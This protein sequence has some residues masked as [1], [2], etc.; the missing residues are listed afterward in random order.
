MTMD[1]DQIRQEIRRLIVEYHKGAKKPLPHDRVPVSGKVY[2]E[3][4]MMNAMEAVLDG[5]WTESRFNTAFE[6]GLASFVGTKY[7]LT[8]NSGSSA[9]LLAFYSLTS[10]KLGE[11]RICRGDEVISVAAAFPTTVNPI[12]QYGAVPVFLDVELGTYDIDLSRIEEAITPKTKAIFLA[13]TLGNPFDIARL[14]ALAEK[15][16]LWL[17][18]DACDALG[19][20]Y[21]G[22]MVGSF[23]D[24]ST[25]SFYPAHQITTA[26]GGA[27]LT[28]NPL[29]H[30]IIRSFRDWG[31]DCWCPTGMD[32]T[33]KK[34]FKWKLGDLPMGYD[35][36]Y[37][38][39]EI[40]FNLK[41]TEFQA[42][43]GLAQIA[44][45]PGFIEKRKANFAY[46]RKRF[47]QEG[48]DRHF[49]MPRD[50]P[51]SDPAW[52][53]FPLTLKGNADRTELL[54]FLNSKN[55]ATRLVFAGNIT[56]Q[57][58]F[59]DN[60]VPYRVVGGLKN[61]DEVMNKTFWIGVYPALE[62][63]H[64][65]YVVTSLKEWASKHAGA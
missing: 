59:V 4:E 14:K 31:R 29:L 34:R 19:S 10:Q 11:R 35:H 43:I 8:V 62:H 41:M 2:D 15:H 21:S 38:Y 49:I 18:E 56:K 50:T 30:R 23:G 48:L 3:N 46:L 1:K 27:V 44:K 9:N 39:S 45:L 57:P 13:H 36:K 6:K 63:A 20:R 60:K 32:D 61:T 22:R 64:M 12:V 26:E 33:C 25:L 40:G 54:E 16:R 42:A 37:I 47:E 65:E 58:Y 5:W 53:G 17:I 51:G 52:F 24:L 28:N 7:A 55:I